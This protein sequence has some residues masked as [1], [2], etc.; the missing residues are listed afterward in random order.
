MCSVVFFE[1]KLLERSIIIH[2]FF[3]MISYNNLNF[4]PKIKLVYYNL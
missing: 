1:K 4:K 3:L 2:Q